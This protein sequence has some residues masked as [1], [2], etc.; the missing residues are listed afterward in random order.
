MIYNFVDIDPRQIDWP[1]RQ[2]NALIP[3]EVIDGIPRNPIGQTG[4]I[5]RRLGEWGE[6]QAADSIVVTRRTNKILLIKRDD[7]LEWAIP[8]GM[9][10]PGELATKTLYRELKEETGVDLKHM[11][12]KILARI[13]IDDYRCSD[14]AWIT[15]T[16]ALY[17]IENEVIAKGADDALDARWFDFSSMEALKLD[18]EKIGVLSMAHRPLFELALE[19]L[20]D[21]EV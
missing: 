7:C 13:Y 18:V 17:V 21:T 4:K 6:N 14:F 3:F 16:V 8:G 12:P 9:V 5:D 19:E 11:T 20:K 1:E 2:R 15:S 10:N